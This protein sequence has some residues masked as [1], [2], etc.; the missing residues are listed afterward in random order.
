MSDISRGPYRVEALVTVTWAGGLHVG[1]GER[2]SA[3]T[4][5]PVLRD[6]TGRPYLPGSSIRGVL[7]D[8]C[9][10]EV[11]VVGVSRETFVR[12]FGPSTGELS[13][14][15]SDRQGRLTVTDARLEVSDKD[16]E[17]RD[18][19][20]LK[21]EWG[22]AAKGGKFDQEVA[23]PTRGKFSLIYE[24]D[25]PDDPELLLLRSGLDALE[26][27]VLAFGGKTGWGLGM[28]RKA[29][30]RYVC[31][32][33][34][35]LDGL[36]GYLA[37]RLGKGQATTHDAWSDGTPRTQNSDSQGKDH[38]S[39]WSWI[40]FYLQLHFDGP[41]LV[42][43]PYR[44]EPGEF[45]TLRESADA[46][47]QVRP[48][49][50]PFVPGSSLRG[51]LRHHAHRIAASLGHPDLANVLFGTI[52]GESGSRGLV[53]VGE[54][55]VKDSQVH[56]IRM[57]HVAIDRITGFAA[58]AK[59]FN[60]AAL[61]SPTIAHRIVVRWD[62]R[63]AQQKAAVALLLFVLRDM[64]EGLLWVG[65]RTTRGYGHV[66]SA[67]ISGFK[68]SLAAKGSREGLAAA[69]GAEGGKLTEVF[70]KGLVEGLLSAWKQQV[71]GVAHG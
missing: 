9:E 3:A 29:N 35:K 23:L 63:N 40:R 8:W 7:R 6:G 51:V 68:G 65:S 30:I 20:R 71:L 26:A 53:R 54:G 11:S 36:A 61:A 46:V 5:A 28:I 31:E 39:P 37:R 16:A 55:E 18:H 14:P 60:T 1:T 42:A 50:T 49:G 10:R 13:D 21:L 57:D 45:Q 25:G 70:D 22:A 56:T 47:F 69:K 64:Q 2:L 58:D 27:G 4:D 38:R 12:L 15:K 33:R 48:D 62:G 52:K 43:G 17:I 34:S 32:D 24:G 67:T 59:L 19:V 41:M 66:K 44:G